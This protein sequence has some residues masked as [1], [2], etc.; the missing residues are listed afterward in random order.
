VTSTVR[1][2]SD[3]LLLFSDDN[4]LSINGVLTVHVN[5]LKADGVP[6]KGC[7]AVNAGLQY[8][9]LTGLD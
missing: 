8:C 5:V 6:E 3:F 9:L 2:W 1:P 7:Q 4:D